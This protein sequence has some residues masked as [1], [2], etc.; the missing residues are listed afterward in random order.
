MGTVG[1]FIYENVYLFAEGSA[2]SGTDTSARDGGK[3]GDHPL[4]LSQEGHK[5]AGHSYPAVLEQAPLSSQ[6]SPWDRLIK[7]SDPY[8][9][10][11]HRDTSQVRR[12]HSL[13]TSSILQKR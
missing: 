3:A 10:P 4:S 5:G 13:H 7:A 12:K 11:T 6:G 8:L 9:H 1:S 2:R